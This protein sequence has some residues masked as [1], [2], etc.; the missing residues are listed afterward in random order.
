MD[1]SPQRPLDRDIAEMC[2]G[3]REAAGISLEKWAQMTHRSA[4]SLSRFER[5]LSRPHDLDTLVSQYVGLPTP[6]GGAQQRL[7]N[8]LGIWAGGFAAWLT[9]IAIAVSVSPEDLADIVR[10]AVLVQTVLV[11]ALTVRAGVVGVIG[12]RITVG[13]V[14]WLGVAAVLVAVRIGSDEHIA[15]SVFLGVAGALLTLGFALEIEPLVMRRRE[16]SGPVQGGRLG[17]FGG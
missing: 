8:D 17:P 12:P 6:S 2:R 3:R 9:A 10:V 16:R 14:L 11:M 4:S 13:A 1:G 7:R 15:P 5:G